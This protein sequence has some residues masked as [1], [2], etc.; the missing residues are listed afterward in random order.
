MSVENNDPY[1][2]PKYWDKPSSRERP[3][4]PGIFMAPSVENTWWNSRNQK[5]VLGDLVIYFHY[6]HVIGFYTPTTGLRVAENWSKSSSLGRVLNEINPD[7]KIR[8]KREDLITE[9]A[10]YLSEDF[11]F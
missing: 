6:Q 5:I 9:L 1:Y 7:K 4:H 2:K 8:I 11:N 10:K 3:L